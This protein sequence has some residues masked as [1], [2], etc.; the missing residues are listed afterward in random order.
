MAA[1]FLQKVVIVLGQ[2]HE[3]ETPGNAKGLLDVRPREQRAQRFQGRGQMNIRRRVSRQSL[4][5][6]R[7]QDG[8]EK[9]GNSQPHVRHGRHH[10]H[11][12]ALRQSPRVD[13]QALAARFVDA[14]EG[15]HQRLAEQTQFE[16][17]FQIT[18]QGGGVNH[19]HQDV[20]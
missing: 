12:E 16:A 2:L 3:Q 11:A 7:R 5:T 19:L 6:R 9:L 15:N 1:E 14:V 17:E 4:V 10:R 20:G 13:V 18:L 8:G